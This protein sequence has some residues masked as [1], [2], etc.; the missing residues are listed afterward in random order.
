MAPQTYSQVLE[1]R[2][3]DIKSSRL[4]STAGEILGERGKERRRKGKR[5]RRERERWGNRRERAVRGDGGG[6]ERE[7]RENGGA[8]KPVSLCLTLFTC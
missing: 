1:G 7:V 2:G 6:M 8:H 5:G 3:G 4:F